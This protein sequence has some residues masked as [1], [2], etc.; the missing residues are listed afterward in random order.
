MREWVQTVL[1]KR[2][3]SELGTTL[4]HEHLVIGWPGWEFDAAAPAFDRAA[5][6]RLCVERMLELKELGLVSLVDPCP[7]DLGRDVEIMVEVAEATGVNIVCAT[8]LY[9]EDQGAAPYFRFRANF[10]D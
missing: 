2:R 6:R 5:V 3:P 8:G 10:S 1:G 7:M 9:K 4:M